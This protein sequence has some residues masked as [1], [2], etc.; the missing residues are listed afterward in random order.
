MREAREHDLEDHTTTLRDLDEYRKES[1]KLRDEGFKALDAWVKERALCIDPRSEPR[2]CAMLIKAYSERRDWPKK[3]KKEIENKIEELTQ[4]IN[5]LTLEDITKS[6]LSVLNAALL[7][8]ALTSVPGFAYSETALLC[9]YWVIRE[10]HS[11]AYPDWGIGGA[12]AH[13]DGSV[14]AFTTGECVRAILSFADAQQNTAEFFTHLKNFMEA[15]ERLD[16]MGN[17]SAL[18]KWVDIEKQRLRLF[19]HF[20]FQALKR[21]FS[22]SETFCDKFYG[23]YSDS[24]LKEFFSNLEEEI[25][26]IIA[27][28]EQASTT[29]KK[30]Y[31]KEAS[32]E[33]AHD[34]ALKVIDDVIKNTKDALSHS[35]NLEK[36]AEICEQATHDLGKTLNPAKNY[37]LTVLDH[38][39]ALAAAG[40]NRQWEPSEL[41]CAAA[42]YGRLTK[43]WKEDHRFQE[44]VSCLEKEN[45]LSDRGMVWTIAPFHVTQKNAAYFPRNADLLHSYAQ[46]LRHV[47]KDDKIEIRPELVGWILRFFKETRA[48]AR[49][50]TNE[51]AKGKEK[52]A[53]EVED[54][55]ADALLDFRKGWSFEHAPPPHRFDSKATCSATLAL[56]R[57]NEMLDERINGIILE[58][59]TVREPSKELNL[60]N[61]FYPDYGLFQI[62]YKIPS[63]PAFWS[64]DALQEWPAL[65][66]RRR[67]SIAF[68]LQRMCAHVARADFPFKK[69]DERE[70][71]FKPEKLRSLVLHGSPGTGKTT[72]VEALAASCGVK[73]VE[74]TPSDIVKWGEAAI[75]QRAR[76]VFDA[77]SLLTHVVIL[78][79]EFDPVLWQRDP[80]DASTRNVFSFLTPGMLPKLKEL[81]GRAK[82]RRVAY[83]LATNL[84]GCL[85]EA[86]VREGRFDEKKGIYPPDIL[87]RV[88]RFVNQ[89]GKVKELKIVDEWDEKR[90]QRLF[91]VIQCTGSGPMEKLGKWF[92]IKDGKWKDSPTFDY[93]FGEGDEKQL[94]IE[95]EAQL[96]GVI[97]RG[98]TAVK[99]YGQWWWIDAWEKQAK[100]KIKET[101]ESYKAALESLLNCYPGKDD[102]GKDYPQKWIKANLDEKDS[103]D[104][105]KVEKLL[106]ET[107]DKKLYDKTKKDLRKTHLKEL[108]D[109]LNEWKEKKEKEN[110]S[111]GQWKWVSWWRRV[112]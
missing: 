100:L 64:P 52:N 72:L 58:H 79:D 24:D 62:P 19:Y 55:K 70:S 32:T 83:V 33:Y 7:L 42:A 77:L 94:N 22:L 47:K 57:I 78:L 74:V 97:G 36:L 93:V 59:F 99:E 110:K 15:K 88:G 23:G 17:V 41:I 40:G 60:D 68:T 48:M 50:L 26:K 98:K 43:E 21:K 96:G 73:L 111:K 27:A 53:K 45:M 92:T 28:A 25:R 51:K 34:L 90:W 86:A 11:S 75:E 46:L 4:E 54:T 2:H 35:S 16:S 108:L 63:P 76:T 107:E 69:G 6:D 31:K 80:N 106:D 102:S 85:D 65:G 87:S 105:A 18:N 109:S 104:K 71:F 67:E 95:S 56:V 112:T 29:I 3:E 61:L 37:L 82:K 14:T 81:N 44:A 12:R 39:L 103:S 8:Q 9:L 30:H 84:I 10:I 101:T 20:T 66:F 89:A 91:K 5:K 1:A 13:P 49:P 38:Q